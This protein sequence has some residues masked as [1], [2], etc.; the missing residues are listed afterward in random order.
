MNML[1]RERRSEE[2]RERAA[3]EPAGG[4]ITN[5]LQAGEDFYSAVD[6]AIN[7]AMSSNSE[8]FIAQIEQENGQ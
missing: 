3:G 7:N 8:L 4:G 5:S 1:Q 2:P 6:N